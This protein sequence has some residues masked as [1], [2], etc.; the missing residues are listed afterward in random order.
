MM[1]KSYEVFA[2]FGLQDMR[3]LNVKVC[4]RLIENYDFLL[5]R[6]R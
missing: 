1:C 2:L 4:Q 3:A 5:H 6:K